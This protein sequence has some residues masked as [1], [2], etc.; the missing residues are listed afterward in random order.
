MP[1]TI[2]TVPSSPLPETLELFVGDSRV[3]AVESERVAVGNG[4]LL[5]VSPV[6][7]DQL[8]LIGQA[9][10]HTVLQIWLRDGRQHRIDV[11]ITSG[12]LAAA[13]E[14]VR[15]LLTGIEGVEARL[16]GQRIVLEGDSPDGRAR[17]RAAAITTLYPGVVVDFLGKVGWETMVHIDVR[18]VEFRR[19]QL[20]ELGIRWRDDINGPSA[21]VIADF[22]TNTRFRSLPEEGTVAE[23]AFNPLPSRTPL[24]GYL[25]IS[26]VLDSRIRALEQ[27]GEATLVAEPRLSC[28]S[29]GSARFVAGGEIPIPVVNS[30]GSTDVEY[31]EYG[32]ILDVKPV[33]D[34]SGAV[35]VRIETELSQVDNAQ[36]VA[37]IPGLL[38]RRSSTDINVR[39]GDTVVIAGLINHQRSIDDAGL[40]GVSRVPVAG[41]LFGVRGRR[42]EDSELVI[43]LTPR[44]ESPTMTAEAVQPAPSTP[45]L[46]E[47]ARQR[48]QSIPRPI[49]KEP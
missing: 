39:S 49:R 34:A 13:L 22:A 19:G 46:V 48:V 1:L 7:K 17:E 12:D 5:T 18:I 23:S 8:V 35:L 40:P 25:G 38:K 4:K 11:R 20:R 9:A 29:G 3:L 2:A 36:R 42:S 41:R 16:V 45:G 14:S 32:V 37:G 6:S 30:V 31:R 10:G 44:I 24:R 28:R 27:S 47:R 15:K 26:S 43:F 21:G 33:V